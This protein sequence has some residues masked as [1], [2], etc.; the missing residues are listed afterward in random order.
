MVVASCTIVT[1]R[2]T[3][4]T[5]HCTTR[6]PVIRW[7]IFGRKSC[8]GEEH[9][10]HVLTCPKEFP[11][12]L[13]A[14]LDIRAFLEKFKVTEDKDWF[15]RYVVRRSEWYQKEVVAQLQGTIE[16]KWRLYKLHDCPSNDQD[17]DEEGDCYHRTLAYESPQVF[18]TYQA[19]KNDYRMFKKT[20]EYLTLKTDNRLEVLVELAKPYLWPIGKDRVRTMGTVDPE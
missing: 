14:T 15:I 18:T 1:L 4:V 13:E 20:P 9:V 3:I 12:R 7:I 16:V 5:P 17:A 6:M 19:C 11:S 10:F 8:Q 2:C